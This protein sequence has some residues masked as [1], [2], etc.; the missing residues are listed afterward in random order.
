M[1][2]RSRNFYRILCVT[3]ITR[4]IRLISDLLLYSM[5]E[6]TTIRC[7]GFIMDGNRRW[8][9]AQDLSSLEGHKRGGEVFA[10]SI[11]WVRDADIPHAVY[12]AFSTENWQRGEKEVQYL[13]ELFRSWMDKLDEKL[14]EN[15][16]A[17]KKIN[18][19]V[20]GRLQDFAADIQERVRD[21]EKKNAEFPNPATT[22]WVAL[23]YGGRSE[24]LEAVNQAVKAGA[25]VTADSFGKL[26]W[27]ADMPDPDMIVR[28]SGE[29]RLSNFL[30]WSSV[31]S[32][33][34]FIDQPWPAL[35]EADFKDILLEYENRERR[36][37]A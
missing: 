28:T 11:R 15:R 16:E 25:G 14:D 31:Y 30:T 9:Q 29:K 22:I 12:Y 36:R 24:I 18:I 26:L 17:A 5:D 19:K 27:T 33:L 32:E 1:A 6:K 20:I 13:M 4:T 3:L 37:G 2:E 34:Y 8:A 35:T 10:D 7:L 21:L 23:S